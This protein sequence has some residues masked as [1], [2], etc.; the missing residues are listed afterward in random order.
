MSQLEVNTVRNVN[1]Q[2]PSCLPLYLN[3][4]PPRTATTTLQKYFFPHLQ[5]YL[6]IQKL[7]YR[8]APKEANQYPW[9]TTDGPRVIGC[10]PTLMLKRLPYLQHE[11]T[12]SS[13]GEG[14][15]ELHAIIRNAAWMLQYRLQSSE[16]AILRDLLEESLTVSL[17]IAKALGSVG[18]LITGEWCS[19]GLGA[20]NPLYSNLLPKGPLP[21]QSI[22]E[23]WARLTG[24][25]PL[26]SFCCR[27]PMSLLRSRH[28]RFVV[29]SDTDQT[30]YKSAY[31][32][33]CSQIESYWS[34]PQQSALFTALHKS[35]L[36]HLTGLGFVRP[37]G[38][39]DL[40]NA[41]DIGK[42]IGID[43]QQPISFKNMPPENSFRSGDKYTTEAGAEISRALEEQ[44]VLN[45]VISEKLYD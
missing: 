14:V 29:N 11:I 32:W 18:I 1:Q 34:S 31:L 19:G 23:A 38:F 39:Q 12:D 25:A 35:F 8:Y 24:Q 10:S 3:I 26:I 33:T 4:G 37:Y 30:K 21:V 9:F 42:L 5:R 16:E 45:R 6:V 36:R 28:Q 22:G 43:T 44:G 17:T 15:N 7:A 20:L 41:E 40:L 13:N 27:E 2:P